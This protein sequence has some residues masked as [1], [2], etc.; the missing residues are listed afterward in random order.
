MPSLY[1][2]HKLIFDDGTQRVE[3]MF[4]GHAHTAG[5]AV[6]WV[7]KHGILFT[8]DACV[9]GAFNYTG[10]SNTESWIAVLGAME[11]LDVKTVCPGHGELMGKELLGLQR[12][13]FFELRAAI[14]KGINA[15]KTLDQI[16]AE[17]DLPFYKEWTGVE[18]KTR[19]E[20]IEHVHREL[21]A[22]KKPLNED[23]KFNAWLKLPGTGDYARI[24]A[25][26]QI[27]K[28]DL[29]RRLSQ[30]AD[31]YLTAGTTMRKQ[32]RDY[33]AG[34]D[35][36]LDELSMYTRRMGKLAA[37][38]NDVAVVRRGLAVAAIEGGRRDYRDTIVSLV[39]LRAGGEQM[40]MNVDPLFREIQHEEF[41]APE[42]RS[43]FES[44]RT[45]MAA[46]VERIVRTYRPKD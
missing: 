8:G 24:G 23:K 12:R 42:N 2:S 44:A 1:F 30:L 35:A 31:L 19:V 38:A 39:L 45:H 46:D 9:N 20:N 32:I 29:D 16:K 7:P 36:E 43:Y 10:D 4:L 18:A 28:C 11:E 17:H 27:G 41:M 3:L 5:D 33:F 34:R 15:G 37:S 6:A 14:Q 21:T 13:Y 40:G 26:E 25:W 22:A